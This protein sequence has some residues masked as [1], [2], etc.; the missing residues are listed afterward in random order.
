MKRSH[1]RLR[2]RHSWMLSSLFRGDLYEERLF[3]SIDG[4]LT[5]HGRR[6]GIPAKWH[7]KKIISILRPPGDRFES[8]YKFQ[9]WCRTPPTTLDVQNLYPAFPKLTPEELMDMKK[10]IWYNQFPQLANLCVGWQS[11]QLVVFFSSQDLR[12]KIDAELFNSKEELF[13]AFIEDTSEVTFLRQKNLSSDLLDLF[14]NH[15]LESKVKTAIQETKLSNVTAD[16]EKFY[17]P[18]SVTQELRSEV[19]RKERFMIEFMTRRGL[20]D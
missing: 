7:S 11:I 18:F 16:I 3:P 2:R 20:M 12:D 5:Q 6:N 1:Q 13:E 4:S 15:R 9:H 10:R 8:I 14:H 17:E 19:E